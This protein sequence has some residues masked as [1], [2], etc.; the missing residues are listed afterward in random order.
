[1]NISI[2][3]KNKLV[4]EAAAAAAA[5]AAADARQQAE[6]LAKTVYDL[7]QAEDE[8]WNELDW[9]SKWRRDSEKFA[10]IIDEDRHHKTNCSNRWPDFTL[11]LNRLL[12]RGMYYEICQRIARCRVSR[13]KDQARYTNTSSIEYIQHL[14]L[15]NLLLSL[16]AEVCE[17]VISRETHYFS[18]NEYWDSVPT[19]RLVDNKEKAHLQRAINLGA[20]T[21][22]HVSKLSELGFSAKGVSTRQKKRNSKKRQRK[23][24]RY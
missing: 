5:A 14:A 22:G 21:Q 16:E 18:T 13:Q 10:H 23:S 4:V 17:N 1:M 9:Q 12:A 19:L 7:Q 6:I 11:E 3:K 24:R 2:K 20:I 8:K 15:I